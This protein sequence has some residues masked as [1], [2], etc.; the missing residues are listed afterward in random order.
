MTISSN[1]SQIKYWSKG[2]TITGRWNGSS[3]VIH[4]LLGEGANGCVYLATKDGQ[5]VAMKVASDAVDLQS[6]V[7]AIS[8]LAKDQHR[9]SLLDV[10]DVVH[11]EACF[12]FYVMSYVPGVSLS[13]FMAN[14]SWEWFGPVGYQ[15]LK[16]LWQFHQQGY[17]YGDL[18]PQNILVDKKGTCQLID[19]GG[20]T[21]FGKGVKQFTELYD[22]G[23]WNGGTRRADVRYDHFSFA[24]LALHLLDQER[25]MERWAK[26]LPQQRSP[27]WLIA[28]C[29]QV[30]TVRPYCKVL[31]KALRGAYNTDEEL[32]QEWRSA[33]HEH[34]R[35]IP[36]KPMKWLKPLF[37]GSIVLFFSVLWLV[38]QS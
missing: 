31:Q 30:V 15:I 3:Y 7:N 18:K 26:E 29:S 2:T 17:V 13:R 34:S 27:E 9:F 36:M 32:L 6:E 14:K 1:S 20:V 22:R 11:G 5:Y 4:G 19:F 12:S 23:F 38:M 24:A 37:V 21:P 25:I 28:R 16:Q 35:Y 33:L 10:D 8:I